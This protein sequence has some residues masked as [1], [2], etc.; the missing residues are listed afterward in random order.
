VKSVAPTHGGAV[1][2]HEVIVLSHDLPADL[3]T[4]VLPVR[5]LFIDEYQVFRHL[6]TSSPRA[7]I[8][9]S[10]DIDERDTE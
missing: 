4:G 1:L 6:F 3:L 2:G 10:I 5:F 7:R 9:G 8:S